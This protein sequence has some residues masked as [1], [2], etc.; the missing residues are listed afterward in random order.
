[1]IRLGF[2]STSCLED[3]SL[4]PKMHLEVHKIDNSNFRGF[5]TIFGIHSYQVHTCTGIHVGNRHTHK[6][7]KIKIWEIIRP[8]GLRGRAEDHIL[9]CADGS[10]I[11]SVISGL[12]SV[13][14]T[15]NQGE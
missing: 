1:M 14:R 13:H 6:I 8:N 10:Q 15:Y 2:R 12:W 11:I 7:I 4:I 5:D 9:R 3:Y